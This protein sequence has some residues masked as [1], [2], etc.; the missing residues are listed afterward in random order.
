K[1]MLVVEN[2]QLIQI[3]GSE[4]KLFE[5]KTGRELSYQ[6]E[7]VNLEDAKV[8]KES[9]DHFMI[10]EIHEDPETIRQV[11]AQDE[12][13]LEKLVS[14]IKGA[15]RIYC[16][17][18][19]TAGI[20]A[21]QIAYYLRNFAKVE[22]TSL[23]GADCVDYF[24]FFDKNTLIIS[25]SQSGET[26]DV[27]E[28]LE[29][30][31]GKGAKIV[32]YVNMQGS[33]M[34]RMA[35]FNFQAQA[36]P[37]IC[38]MSTK[39]FVSQVA[40]GYLLAKAVAGQLLEAKVILN[41]TVKSLESYL[42]DE[43]ILG[44]VKNL[45]KKLST[46]KD[47]FLLAKAQ[48]LQ[49]AR[50]GMVKLIEGSYRHAHAIPAGDLKHYAITIMEEGVPVIVLLSDDEVQAD[51]LTAAAEVK[52]RGATVI[53][54]GPKNHNSFES[55]LPVFGNKEASA[56]N[57]TVALQLLSYYL[58]LE[59]GNDVDHPRNIAKSVTVK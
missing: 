45:A 44:Q 26:A 37:E 38:V 30:A 48:N 3:L 20:A 7:D 35:D 13:K 59:L 27:L 9:F 16:I 39:V 11:I 31:K 28:V 1:K 50:E 51:V 40:W 36:G 57:M 24:D 2:G 49:I 14:A 53:G 22:A 25:P 46:A 12:D 19:G 47:I 5:I 21:A 4:L 52:A 17:G 34:S 18:S 41:Q 8:D 10:K 56:I 23:V 58:T 6:L 33:S 15:K 32:S 43:K 29:I 42:Q 54:L 55:Y